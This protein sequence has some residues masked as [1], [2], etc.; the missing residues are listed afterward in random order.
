M[1]GDRQTPSA[2]FE[3]HF[4]RQQDGQVRRFQ[5]EDRR[6]WRCQEEG[7]GRW[8]KE[9]GQWIQRCRQCQEKEGAQE[10]KSSTYTHGRKCWHVASSVWRMW[11]AFDAFGRIDRGNDIDRQRHHISDFDVSFYDKNG[12][13]CAL[14]YRKNPYPAHTTFIYRIN[15]ENSASRRYR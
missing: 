9:Q 5:E 6:W 10:G 14:F 3:C 7:T 2:F 4:F 13:F 15:N 1:R 11:D 8:Q 12:A